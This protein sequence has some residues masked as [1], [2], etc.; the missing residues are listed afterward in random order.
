MKF[1]K[2]YST[3][4]CYL[5]LLALVSVISFEVSSHSDLLNRKT[6]ISSSKSGISNFMNLVFEEENDTDDQ[7]D[8]SILSLVYFNC[9]SFSQVHLINYYDH[10][11]KTPEINGNTKTP[12]FISQRTLRI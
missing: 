10:F 12:L 8:H 2:I 1:K 11:F 6:E 3:F 7:I 9:K 5:T 4:I